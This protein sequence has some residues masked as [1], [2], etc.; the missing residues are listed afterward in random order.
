MKKIDEETANKVGLYFLWL[1]SVYFGPMSANEWIHEEPT[2]LGFISF[3][4]CLYF[5][6]MLFCWMVKYWG[7]LFSTV[8]NAFVRRDD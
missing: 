6:V 8:W 3:V 1:V 7:Y 4:C 5:G 2:F